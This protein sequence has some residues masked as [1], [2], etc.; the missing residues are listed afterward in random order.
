MSRSLENILFGAP[1]P[2]AQAVTRAMSALAAAALLALAAGIVYR[3]HNAG[4]LDA[5][6]W[7][8]FA[9]STTWSFLG[10]GLLGTMASA[11]MAA[12]IALGLGLV[13]MLGRL[14][15]LR[16]LRKQHVGIPHAAIKRVNQNPLAGFRV[17]RF[18]KSHR[19]K[20]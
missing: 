6:F 13:L 16:L 14:A 12:V 2:R 15:P 9:W 7:N 8:F 20:F 18:D 4:Q 5:R 1:S 19:R 10:K 3:F 17:F 11:A